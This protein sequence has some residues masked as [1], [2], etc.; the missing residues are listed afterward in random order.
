MTVATIDVSKLPCIAPQDVSGAYILRQAAGSGSVGD[1]KVEA[2]TTGGLGGI[3]VGV[4]IKLGSERVALIYDLAPMIEATAREV[5]RQ[6]GV[7]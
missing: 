2:W 4:D 6:A 5:M 1:V 3:A 7:S